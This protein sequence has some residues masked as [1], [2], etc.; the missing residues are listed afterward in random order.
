MVFVVL[1]QF[2]EPPNLRLLSACTLLG[3]S[4]FLLGEGA[5]CVFSVGLRRTTGSEP[6]FVCLL[7]CTVHMGSS[8]NPG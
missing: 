2:F 5:D 8:E 1:R 7:L 6:S 3:K 4:M